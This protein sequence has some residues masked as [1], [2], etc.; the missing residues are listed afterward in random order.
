MLQQSR[1]SILRNAVLGLGVAT[2]GCAGSSVDERVDTKPPGSPPL[3]P[4]GEWPSYRFDAAN[5]GANLDGSGVRDGEQYWRLDAGGAATVSNGTLYNTRSRGEGATK[6]TYRDPTT[7]AVTTR[8]SLVE[9]G[10]NPP[11]TVADG[12]IFVN[13]FIEVFC[14]DAESGEQRWRGPA[15]NGIRGQPTVADDLVFVATV[16]FDDARPQLRAFDA[17]SGESVWQYDAADPATLTPAVADGLVFVGDVD[18]LHAVDSAT[19]EAA[20]VAADAPSER[21]SPAVDAGTAYVVSET[22]AGSD[23]V[24]VTTDDGTVRWRTALDRS[25]ADVDPTPVVAGDVVYTLTDDGLTAL[26]PSDGSVVVTNPERAWPVGRVGDVVYAAA[27]GTV[28]AF[29]AT[30]GLESLWSIQ[31]EDVQVQDTAGRIVHHVTPVDGAVYVSAR[32]AFHGIGPAGT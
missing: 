20:Y 7:A 11:P 10:V 28:F 32:D 13:T 19:G 17:E 2:T 1:R 31:T 14:F 23:L 30:A 22:E 3:D 5:T 26:D 4:D 8:R 25:S 9:Y 16:G 15:M 24:A 29:D 18:G 12:C 6:L 21:G 27:D